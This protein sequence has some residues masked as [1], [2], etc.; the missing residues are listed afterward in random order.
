[1]GRR[2][3]GGDDNV[4]VRAVDAMKVLNLAKVTVDRDQETTTERIEAMLDEI[5]WPDDLR[6]IDVS[7]TEVQAASLTNTS[8]LSHIQDVAASE[9]GLFFIAA[10]GTATFFDRFHTVS[11]E[12]DDTWGELE[13]ELRLG[14]DV[15]RRV[16]TCGT[17]S[18]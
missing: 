4:Q 17:R 5:A 1:M 7:E 15:L 14:H 10:D 18:W 16:A 13:S 6:A 3:V 12:D 2:A 8:V 9:G 11:L